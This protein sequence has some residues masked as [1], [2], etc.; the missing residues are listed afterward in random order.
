MQY[1]I[2]MTS[3]DSCTCRYSCTYSCTN[4]YLGYLLALG[5]QFVL[6]VGTRSTNARTYWGLVDDWIPP[7]GLWGTLGAEA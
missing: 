5:T 4:R 1:A 2:V 3:D 7:T 6:A